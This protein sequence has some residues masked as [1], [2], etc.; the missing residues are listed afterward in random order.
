MSENVRAR[1]R[2]VDKKVGAVSKRRRG[3][4]LAQLIHA[5]MGKEVGP[6]EV[7]LEPG[8]VPLEELIVASSTR[9][10]EE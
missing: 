2:A 9:P 8:E 4:S 5:A 10:H 7:E 6:P 1:L 3:Y